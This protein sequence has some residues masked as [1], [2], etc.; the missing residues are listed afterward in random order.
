MTRS[1]PTPSAARIRYTVQTPTLS[2]RAM[3]RRSHLAAGAASPVLIE[4]SC[5]HWNNPLLDPSD[6]LVKL[7]AVLD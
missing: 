7:D 6:D 3:R 1:Y 5:L 4:R 2:S